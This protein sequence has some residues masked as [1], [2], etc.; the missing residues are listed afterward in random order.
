V[1]YIIV[2]NGLKIASSLIIHPMCPID[3]YAIIDRNCD[4]FIP[5]I[6]PNNLLIAATIKISCVFCSTKNDKMHNGASFCHVDK[7]R[8]DIH[9][10]EAI[11]DG[12]QKWHG[13]LPSLSIS[14]I[15]KNGT[16]KLYMIDSGIHIK[17]LLLSSSADPSACARK[18]LIAPSASWLDF[19]LR[20]T[21]INL[22]KFSSMAAQINNQFELDV[23]II[24]LVTIVDSLIIINGDCR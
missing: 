17:K 10:I 5:I 21:G 1:K 4:W 9:E 2:I 6:P 23:A 24:V 12:Y 16:D 20:I 3:E 22:I 18:Y 11:T 14:E 13:N 15:V 8:Q 19:D 7:I